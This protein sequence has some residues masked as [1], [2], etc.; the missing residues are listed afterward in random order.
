MSSD[1]S[2]R[3]HLQHVQLDA[4][5]GSHWDTS[6]KANRLLVWLWAVVV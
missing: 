4:A 3:D 6:V 2:E 5:T 1:T